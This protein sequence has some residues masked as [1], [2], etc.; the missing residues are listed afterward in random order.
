MSPALLSIGKGRLSGDLAT[1]LASCKA[2]NATVNHM[3][4]L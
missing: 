1:G 4:L 2:E 3:K